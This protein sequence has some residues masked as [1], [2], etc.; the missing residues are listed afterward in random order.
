MDRQKANEIATCCLELSK[1]REERKLTQ[2]Q[3]DYELAKLS[4]EFINDY[5]PRQEPSCPYEVQ[6]FL[7]MN[8]DEKKRL[9][10]DELESLKNKSMKWLREKEVIVFE[11]R[12]H[13]R[14]LLYIEN[15]LKEKNNSGALIVQGMINE[16][17]S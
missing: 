5:G 15:I 14:W 6:M 17:K 4:L 12:S 11:N 7:K 1:A 16:Y 3:L 8:R 13:L 9:D 2:E 10:P